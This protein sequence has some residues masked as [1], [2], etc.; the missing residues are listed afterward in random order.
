[1]RARCGKLFPEPRK[2]TSFIRNSYR[3]ITMKD[4]RVT[5]PTVCSNICDRILVRS[6]MKVLPCGSMLTEIIKKYLLHV[7]K[8]VKHN[9]EYDLRRL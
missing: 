6:I 7:D 8:K 5:F 2:L 3:C 9:R 4:M 1:M